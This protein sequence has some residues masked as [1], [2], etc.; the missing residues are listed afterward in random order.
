M[1][2][3]FGAWSP[4]SF[5]HIDWLTNFWSRSPISSKHMSFWFRFLDLK[6]RWPIK[7]RSH[8]C[9]QQQWCISRYIILFSFIFEKILDPK[10]IFLSCEVEGVPTLSQ[11]TSPV[12][13]WLFL[14]TWR[15]WSHTHSG[16]YPHPICPCRVC[17]C[18]VT[19]VDSVQS[20]NG[21]HFDHQSNQETTGHENW[22]LPL[23]H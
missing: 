17:V 23:F 8:Y 2:N 9:K 12:Q 10:I 20:Q 19:R 11:K 15:W 21:V 6:Y 7:A 5:E 4:I 1:A 16:E 13:I 3:K 22:E 18:Q 14:D